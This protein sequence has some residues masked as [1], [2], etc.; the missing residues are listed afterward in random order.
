M[1]ELSKNLLVPQNLQWISSFPDSESFSKNLEKRN[2]RY[3]HSCSSKISIKYDK[4]IKKKEKESNNELASFNVS[5]RPKR[6]HSSI[7]P[8]ECIF[9]GDTNVLVKLDR[10]VR[11]NEIYYHGKC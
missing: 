8:F 11:T 7:F 9:L 3:H 4:L 5:S 6:K 1:I 10:D 2:A